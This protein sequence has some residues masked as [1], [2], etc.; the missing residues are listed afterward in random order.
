MQCSGVQCRD[1]QCSTEKCSKVQRGSVHFREVVCKA[2][3]F[4]GLH[5]TIRNC[6]VKSDAL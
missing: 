5:C 4:N 1:V 6:V 3:K 2:E